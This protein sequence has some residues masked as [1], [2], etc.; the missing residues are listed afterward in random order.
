MLLAAYVNTETL[1]T[2]IILLIFTLI[3]AKLLILQE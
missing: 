1:E 3:L 2:M